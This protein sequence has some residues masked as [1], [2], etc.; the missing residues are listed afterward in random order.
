MQSK[1]IVIEDNQLSGMR[2]GGIFAIGEGHI[3]RNNRMTHLNTG[4]C[5][6]THAAFGC[7]GIPGEPEF[8]ESGIYLAKGGERPA[9]ARNITIENNII[10][11]HKMAEHCIGAAPSVKLSSNIIRNNSCTDE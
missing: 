10:S 5:E 4:R 9:P 2:F 11:G 7:F 8:L 1:N 6:E 3:I